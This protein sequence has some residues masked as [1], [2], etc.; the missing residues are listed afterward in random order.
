MGDRNAG[1]GGGCDAGA[2]PR[3]DLKL[4]SAL[5]KHLALLATAPKHKWVTAL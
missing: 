1:I 3:D 5:G 4:D 2:D